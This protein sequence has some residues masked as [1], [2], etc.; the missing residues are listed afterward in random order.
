MPPGRDSA[1]LTRVKDGRSWRIGD[2]STVAWIAAGT[3][4][5]LT[6]TSAIPPV[7]DDYATIV[8]PDGGR[9]AARHDRLVVTLLS[10]H[11]PDQPWWLGVPRHRRR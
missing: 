2:S 1:R 10:T 5:G 4:A 11:S 3:V 9:V 7:F 6:I 8:I